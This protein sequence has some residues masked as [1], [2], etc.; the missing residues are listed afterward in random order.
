MDFKKAFGSI[1]TTMQ[2]LGLLVFTEVS[3]HGFNIILLPGYSVYGREILILNSVMSYLEYHKEVSLGLFFFV[4]YVND[5]PSA[6]HYAIPYM[7]A[8]NTKVCNY[9]RS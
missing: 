3:F 2:L 9:H 7:F 4:I 6:L 8:D 1:P 5:L